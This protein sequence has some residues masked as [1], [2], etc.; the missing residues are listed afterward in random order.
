VRPDDLVSTA[1]EIPDDIATERLELKVLPREWYEMRNESSSAFGDRW[2][3]AGT[4]VALHVPSA[5]RRMECGC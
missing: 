3:R 2:I 1:A 4:T 5:S